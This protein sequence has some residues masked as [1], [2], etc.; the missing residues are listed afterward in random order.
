MSTVLIQPDN[1]DK[2]SFNAKLWKNINTQIFCTYDLNIKF[3]VC[4][5]MPVSGRYYRSIS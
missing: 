1:K 2:R 5:E 4:F 3:R